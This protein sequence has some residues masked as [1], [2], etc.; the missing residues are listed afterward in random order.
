MLATP[1]I[2]GAGA[3]T[4]LDA[5]KAAE[6]FAFSEVV[7]V[8]F[9]VAFISGFAAIAFMMSFLRAHSLS[10]FVGYRLALAALILILLRTGV[11]SP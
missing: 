2:V 5:Q 11:L 4:L 10:W 1:I 6:L 9:A 8:G 3:K 7:A